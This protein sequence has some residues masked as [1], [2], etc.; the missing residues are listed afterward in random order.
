MSSQNINLVK[1]ESINTYIKPV[2]TEYSNN[3]TLPVESA[4]YVSFFD[5]NPTSERINSYIEPVESC[6]DIKN[7]YY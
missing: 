4:S 2:K 5:Y 1:I 3:Y 6:C 7:D